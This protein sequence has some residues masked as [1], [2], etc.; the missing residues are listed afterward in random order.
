MYQKV[1][2]V[3]VLLKEYFNQQG[4][5]DNNEAV[6][7]MHYLLRK[8]KNPECDI[9]IPK[10]LCIEDKKEYVKR[11][12]EGLEQLEKMFFERFRIL[13]KIIRKDIFKNNEK[14]DYSRIFSEFSTNMSE[15]TS[16]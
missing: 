4:R 8:Y 7:I 16:E 10:E 1:V 5:I 2:D 3:E 9:V 15:T 14:D 12:D 11:L 13:Y 6:K